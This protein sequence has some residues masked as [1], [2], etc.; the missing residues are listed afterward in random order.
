MLYCISGPLENL[1]WEGVA[2]GAGD[3]G[4]NSRKDNVD[5]NL[6]SLLIGLQYRKINV[7]L[8]INSMFFL[9]VA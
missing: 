6:K 3:G 4:N 1:G 2:E 5:K 9:S 7:K 8:E